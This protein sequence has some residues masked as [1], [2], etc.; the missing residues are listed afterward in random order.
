MQTPLVS[1]IIPLYNRKEYIKETIESLN[2]QTYFHWE[3]IIVDD[4]STDGSDQIVKQQEAHNNRVRYVKRNREPKGAPTCRNIGI[5]MAAG[6]YA[7]FLDS[8]DLLAPFCLQKRV[9]IIQ[10]EPDLDFAVFNMMLFKEKLDDICILWNVSTGQDAL[11][12]FLKMDGV[13]SITGPIHRITS[14]RKTGGFKEGLRFWQD[15]EFHIRYLIN[16]PRYKLFLELE[17]DTYNR[18]HDLASIS[19]KGLQKKEDLSYK[20]KI[21]DTFIETIGKQKYSNNHKKAA[22]STVLVQ[23]G[24]WI[25]QFRDVETG[26]ISWKRSK[27]LVGKL[28]YRLGKISLIL[29]SLYTTNESW[30]FLL[31]YKVSRSLMHPEI[32]KRN[33][34]MCRVRYEK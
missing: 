32:R 33:T 19:Q 8:D 27:P 6:E 4:D 17:P 24:Q 10:K 16:Q 15:Y 2:Q 5:D 20:E 26:L 30:L 25:E 3:A 23:A 34:K 1:V 13:W 7:I 9:S 29:K 14:L 22:A 28:A 31:L 12:R 18:R 21:F 11:T